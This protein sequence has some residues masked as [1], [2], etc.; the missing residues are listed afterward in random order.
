MPHRLP[1][2]IY[3]VLCVGMESRASAMPGQVFTT[4]LQ[5]NTPPLFFLRWASTMLPKLAP[6]SS[7]KVIFLPQ[8]AEKLG[9]QALTTTPTSH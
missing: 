4:G 1:E 8:P 6:K 5:P 2:V 3:F 9:L 7:A